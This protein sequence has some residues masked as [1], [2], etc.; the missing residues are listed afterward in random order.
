MLT[1][2]GIGA[3]LDELAGRTAIPLTIDGAGIPRFTAEAEAAA[4]FFVAEAITNATKHTTATRV[5]VRLDAVT[6]GWRVTVSD[7]GR[8]GADPQRGTGLQGIIE[9]AEA[10]GASVRVS[11]PAGGPTELSLHLPDGLARA[12][13]G[14]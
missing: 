4:Y 11:S 5:R 6:G 13:E 3:A 8:G 7:D 9:R 1:D 12:A 2:H 14:R 10:L